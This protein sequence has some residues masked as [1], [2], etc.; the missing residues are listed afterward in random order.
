MSI[1]ETR[2]PSRRDRYA[3]R[4]SLLHR[5]RTTA[6]PVL[7]LATTA[8][9]VPSR[10][11]GRKIKTI[12]LPRT[13]VPWSYSSWKSRRK[14]RRPSVAG[15][16]HNQTLSPLRTPA[17]EHLAAPD[18]S[19]AHAKTM[20]PLPAPVVRLVSPLQITPPTRF[21]GYPPP[22]STEGHHMPHGLHLSICPGKAHA[23]PLLPGSN[24]PAGV[25]RRP[26]AEVRPPARPQPP[27]IS[28][29][30]AIFG[31]PVKSHCSPWKPGVRMP[32]P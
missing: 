18:R 5:F 2:I 9:R 19:H 14:R 31:S 3:S 15:E 20:R 8:H 4:S 29:D 27:K 23:G 21:G 11:F 10:P 6:P 25:S 28:T 22:S 16:L 13:A 30:Y 24:G 26:H 32:P 17:T 1:P 12:S 7:R